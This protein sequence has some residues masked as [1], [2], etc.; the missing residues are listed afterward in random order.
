MRV[1]CLVALVALVLSG[2]AG[3]TVGDLHVLVTG[4]S[5]EQAASAADFFE[6]SSFGRLHLHI[7]VT[8]D[9][10]GYDAVVSGGPNLVRRLGL[11]FGLKPAPRD[12]LSPMGKGKLDF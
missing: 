6:R 10:D 3:A 11:P 9:P 1:G 4:A 5:S 7:D 8:G 12:P 2:G